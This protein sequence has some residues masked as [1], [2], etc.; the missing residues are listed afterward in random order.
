MQPTVHE[1]NFLGGFTSIRRMSTTTTS[2]LFS[3]GQVIAYDGIRCAFFL[4]SHAICFTRI[5]RVAPFVLSPPFL[6][7]FILFC[8]AALPVSLFPN[9]SPVSWILSTGRRR[10]PNS[11]LLVCLFSHASSCRFFFV[12]RA[13]WDAQLPVLERARHA[14]QRGQGSMRNNERV[15]LLVLILLPLVQKAW[16]FRQLLAWLLVVVLVEFRYVNCCCRCCCWCCWCC[17]CATKLTLRQA[18]PCLHVVQEAKERG[19]AQAVYLLH[20]LSM[21]RPGGRPSKRRLLKYSIVHVEAVDLVPSKRG[22]P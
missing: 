7:C 20:N 13:L 1:F 11:L 4:F 17:F 3:L 9:V 21:S 10:A 19:Y 2:F 12:R 18:V 6:F 16:V 8:P 5:G 14:H 15:V 22:S